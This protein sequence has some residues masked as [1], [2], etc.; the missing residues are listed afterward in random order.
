NIGCWVAANARAV[1]ATQHPMFD[2]NRDSPWKT[3]SGQ[4][5]AVA[6]LFACGSCFLLSPGFV[7]WLGP[8]SGSSP[9]E[10]FRARVA[11]HWWS[12][13]WFGLLW[14]AFT[15]NLVTPNLI[16]A[17][18]GIGL[19]RPTREQLQRRRLSC[20]AAGIVACLLLALL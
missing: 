17:W 18:R 12:V 15:V 10:V 4:F 16:A 6:L 8:D 20:L 19:I 13:L 1:T 7:G 14:P 5:A 11:R 9:V 3:S 2:R